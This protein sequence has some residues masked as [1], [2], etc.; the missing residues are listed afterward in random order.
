MN[1]QRDQY[2]IIALYLFISLV[3]ILFLLPKISFGATSTTIYDNYPFPGGSVSAVTSTPRKLNTFSPINSGILHSGYSYLGGGGATTTFQIRT[4]GG[5]TILSTSNEVTETNQDHATTTWTGNL[6]LEAGTLYEYW[7]FNTSAGINMPIT[8]PGTIPAIGTCFAL[9]QNETSSILSTGSITP[10]VPLNL[11]STPDF[12]NW[13]FN[14]NNPNTGTGN[15]TQ[16]S[17]N[18]GTSSIENIDIE[19]NLPTGEQTQINIFKN[20]TLATGTWTAYV[21]LINTFETSSTQTNT[22]L[23]STTITFTITEGL[24]RGS[25]SGHLDLACG[26]IADTIQKYWC[27]ILDYTIRPHLDYKTMIS[28]SL[29]KFKQIFPFSIYFAISDPIN[30]VLADGNIATTTTLGLSLKGLNGSNFTMAT[31]TSST[32]KNAFT[33]SPYTTQFGSSTGCDSACAQ[34][35]VDNLFMPIKMGGWI[36]TG[37]KIVAM[38]AAF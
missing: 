33:V 18:Y 4:I 34:D 37:M 9:Y 24:F 13:V 26:D 27:Y 30:E 29:A 14:Y 3:M 21:G 23:T 25:T 8:C 1:I 31:L 11:E 5:G 10:V 7:G 22:I 12:N 20:N 36:L 38:I 35:K 32:L 6:L 17:I 2:G 19:Y 16:I 28:N 15:S